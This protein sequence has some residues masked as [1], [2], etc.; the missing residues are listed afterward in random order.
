MT[1]IDKHELG[2]VPEF[3]LRTLGTA[4]TH[5]YLAEYLE[6]GDPKLMGLLCVGHDDF[7]PVTSQGL[8]LT[9]MIQ[10]IDYRA[11]PSTRFWGLHSISLH[12][13]N[14]STKVTWRGAWPGGLDPIQATANDVVQCFQLTEEA[15]LISPELVCFTYPGRH[16]SPWAVQCEFDLF[17]KTLH[18]LSL[19]RTGD[20][21][22]ASMLP[23]W[24]V[25][26]PAQ[27]PAQIEPV[28]CRSG[29][30]VPLTGVWQ[31]DLP[32]GHPKH[33]VIAQAPHRYV[34]R[35]VDEPMVTMG[36]LPFDESQVLWTW[37][38]KQ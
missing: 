7:Y 4:S 36:L 14:A 37:L 10:D 5:H 28:T 26:E 20:W 27:T 1:G 9:L 6:A 25:I 17:S 38:R 11:P 34:Y 12:S 3:L 13:S 35:R 23:P 8:G 15:A 29:Q 2:D 21:L 33:Q 19:I 31:A 32:A 24:P 16:D 22:M 30:L 18:T